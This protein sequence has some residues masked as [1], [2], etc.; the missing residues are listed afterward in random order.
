MPGLRDHR[1]QL[2]AIDHFAMLV[3]N[4]DAI[5][6]AIER[7]ADIGPHFLDLGAQRVRRGRAHL[8]VDVEA[9]R[10][11]ADREH[12]GAQLPQRNGRHL[13]GGAIGA[14]DHHAQ[15]R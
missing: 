7:D 6:V 10:L 1:H 13:V 4:D 9:V 2:V 8:V 3:D 5:G 14:V 12:F 15:P 11:D